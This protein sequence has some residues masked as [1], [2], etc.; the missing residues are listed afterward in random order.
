MSVLYLDLDNHTM[1]VSLLLHDGCMFQQFR[2]PCSCRDLM[3]IFLAHSSVFGYSDLNHEHRGLRLVL[4]LD[5]S[6]LT[7]ASLAFCNFVWL[8][9]M[10]IAV[11]NQSIFF[12][13]RRIIFGLA[14]LFEP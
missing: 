1:I 3:L 5:N 6:K 10:H 7:E 4:I 8:K 9:T 13:T 11:T 2:V 12:Q 14:K